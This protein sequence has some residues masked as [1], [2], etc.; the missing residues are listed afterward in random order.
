MPTKTD[1]QT[2]AKA[3]LKEMDEKIAAVQAKLS[4]LPG[5]ARAK[6]ESALAAMRKSR[7]AFQQ[8]LKKAG[9]SIQDSSSQVK[10]S[11]EAHLN[12]FKESA[13]KA[14]PHSHEGAE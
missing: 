6:A 2:W 5:E 11:L 9:E 4:Q 14:L 1:L 7:D 12:D 10:A 8:A 13:K 3:Q